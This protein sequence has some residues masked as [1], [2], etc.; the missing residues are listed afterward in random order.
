LD[1]R[2]K[3]FLKMRSL[4]KNILSEE[5][6]E[7]KIPNFFKRRVDHH[8]FEKMMRKGI[9]YMFYESESLEEFKW[10][11]V[12]ATLENYIFYKYNIDLVDLNQ[13][14]VDTFIRYMI[15]TYN[16]LLVA[17]YNNMR[18]TIRESTE[19]SKKYE[20]AN[21]FLRLRNLE[22]W[23]N[24]KYRM[25]YLA[26]KKGTILFM[27]EYNT[28]PE[29]TF[30]STESWLSIQKEIYDVLFS[31][32][33]S[34]EEMEEFLTGYVKKMGFPI[35]DK[36]Y[37]ERSDNVGVIEDD[38]EAIVIEDLNESKML[39]KN[40]FAKSW[41]S[42]YNDLNKYK[43]ED[44]YYIYLANS[45]GTIMVQLNTQ[46]NE[47]AVSSAIWT[48]LEKHFTEK[49]TRRK[50]IGWL[51]DQY[52]LTNMGYV[53]KTQPSV[54][55][56]I[57]NYDTLMDNSTINESEEKN[58]L[59]SYFFK[60]WDKEKNMGKIPRISNLSRLGLSK[61]RNEVVELYSEYMGYNTNYKT[62]SID[63]FL[64][65]NEFTEKDIEEIK[66]NLPDGKITVVF[67]DV[68]FTDDDNKL[69]LDVSFTILDGS[70]YSEDDGIRLNFSSGENPFDDFQE[71]YDFKDEVEN[72]VAKFV[73]E[74]LESFGF[75]INK[76]FT[77]IDVVWG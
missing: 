19:D 29:L 10:K 39:P 62:D 2:K 33:N 20:L 22:T 15:E 7:N 76:D 52:N 37:I 14:D 53:Y 73:F 17:Y 24:D 55:G 59:K 74:V 42:K 13:E 60:L 18:K 49:E 1:G 8:K 57:S 75:D 47:T 66:T 44:G 50:I 48:I 54:L 68:K 16:P 77:S 34:E 30:S 6:D 9:S 58:P 65:H 35:V 31:I 25:Y 36:L 63:N 46:V 51:L 28:T 41:L 21:N 5:F 70:F 27:S 67:D 64:S 40:K 43:S 12:K 38:D 61:K 23:K 26:T 69:F 3:R 32:F 56:K 72:T 71:F 11:L 45:N 4:I